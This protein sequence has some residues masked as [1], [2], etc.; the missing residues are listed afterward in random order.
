MPTAA[1]R[2]SRL[3]GAPRFSAGVAVAAAVVVAAL[4]AESTAALSFAALGGLLLVAGLVRLSASAV[5]V[6]AIGL[7][8]AVL[9]T[10]A[11]GK[12]PEWYLG[13]TVPAMLA[14]TVASYAL[15]LGRQV[16]REAPTLRVE[17]VNLV[18]TLV[19]LVVGSGVGYLAYRSVV[20]GRTPLALALLV[21]AVV[22]FTVTLR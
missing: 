16:G 18:S 17:L 14:W 8:G 21:L 20:G 7:F 6:G 4:V 3:V 1:D 19:V 22:A 2:P 13:A 15:R 10:G 5:A 9:L 11:G 12:P